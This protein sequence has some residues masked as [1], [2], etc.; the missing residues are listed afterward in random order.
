MDE[1]N[2]FIKIAEGFD[3]RKN[4]TKLER[5]E[6]LAHSSVC[7][8]FCDNDSNNYRDSQGVNGG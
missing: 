7:E 5:S 8:M 3:A 1:N 4:P 2:K 6:E